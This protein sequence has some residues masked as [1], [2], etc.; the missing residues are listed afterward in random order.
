MSLIIKKD[1]ELK[2]VYIKLKDKILL[3][4]FLTLTGIFNLN[5]DNS[6]RVIAHLDSSKLLMGYT[7]RLRLSVEQPKDAKVELP[8]LKENR[9]RSYI[10]L[11]GDSI[12]ISPQPVLDTTK[13]S[14]DRIRVNYNLTLQAF[15]SGYYK[16]PEFIFTDGEKIIKSNRVEL[17]VLPV[18]VAENAQISGFTSIEE[19]LAEGNGD[20]DKDEHSGWFAKYWWLIV[21]LIIVVAAGV[22]GVLKYKK[23]GTL[24]PLKPVIPPYEEATES[25]NTLKGKRLWEK[26]YEKDYYTT[27]TYI[28]RRYIFRE[29]GIPAMEMT[30][31]QIMAA[32]K[33]D[34]DLKKEGSS[35]RNLL[36]LADFVKYA[37]VRP[38]PEDNEKAF[39]ETEDFIKFAHDAYLKREALLA[40]EKSIN[41]KV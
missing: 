24:L 12:E 15:D 32:L 6:V 4:C 13:I 10:G 27:L 7:T 38:L 18:K 11:L 37:K 3:F 8:I 28:L 33:K 35:I 29:Y 34:E 1:K 20:F 17:T 31:R 30:S 41:G 2:S 16:L 21:L 39:I 22:W 26:G 40:E 19:P 23:E 9:G 5:A 25:L 36:D 14:N